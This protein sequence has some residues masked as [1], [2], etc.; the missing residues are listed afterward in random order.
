LTDILTY[1]SLCTRIFIKK[2][3]TPIRLHSDIQA[4]VR[5]SFQTCLYI[6]RSY[7]CSTF[8]STCCSRESRVE[9]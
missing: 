3:I 9:V 6:R 2:A 7:C 8:T 5:T 1:L 4:V